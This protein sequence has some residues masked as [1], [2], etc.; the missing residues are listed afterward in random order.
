MAATS[1]RPAGKR[2]RFWHVWLPRGSAWSR[3]QLTALFW[4]DRDEEQARGSL[5]EALV[6][7]R[8]CMGEPSPLQASRE[9]ISLEP[10]VIGVDAIEVPRLAKA[11]E[12][13][14]ASEHY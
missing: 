7:L 2:A 11:G 13:E 9:T 10:A 8:R 14:P 1:P 5:R 12:L 3:E 4:G 6:K